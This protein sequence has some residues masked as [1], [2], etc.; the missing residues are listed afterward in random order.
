VIYS[1]VAWAKTYLQKARLLSFPKRGMLQITERGQQVLAE[2]HSSI[3]TKFLENFDEFMEF[4]GLRNSGPEKKFEEILSPKSN[5]RTPEETLESAYLELRQ[6]LAD[7]LMEK[8]K[9][10]SPAFFEQ[11]V[12]DLLVAMGYGGSRRDAG[13]RIGGVADEG[14]DGIIKEDKLGLDVI[15]I[16]AKRWNSS[17]S[18]PEIQKFVGALSGKRAKKGVYLTTSWFTKEAIDFAE[19]LEVKVI[20]I[21]GPQIAEYMIDLGLGVSPQAIYEVK[22][23]DSDYFAEE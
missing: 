9:A 13:E 17:V 5:E 22:R 8:I 21:D 19:G 16:Q 14:I 7:E 18:R 3:S 11:L 4:R 15:Y 10:C 23:L 6:A 20:L 12:V 2:G 1:R